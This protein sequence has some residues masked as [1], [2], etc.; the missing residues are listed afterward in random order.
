VLRRVPDAGAERLQRQVFRLAMR[1]KLGAQ[2]CGA[3]R[4]W[5]Q[6]RGRARALLLYTVGMT[7][8]RGGYDCFAANHSR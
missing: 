7:V 4:V 8:I 1:T 5:V 6:R 3:R 2:P